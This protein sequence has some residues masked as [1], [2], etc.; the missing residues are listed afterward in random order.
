MARV[1]FESK[2]LQEFGGF[3][4]RVVSKGSSAFAYEVHG[5]ADAM[6]VVSWAAPGDEQLKQIK[7][8]LL[9]EYLGELVNRPKAA[10]AR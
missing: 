6:E 3:A 8:D 1:I 10:I 5:A 9:Q 7:D 4:Y 2:T